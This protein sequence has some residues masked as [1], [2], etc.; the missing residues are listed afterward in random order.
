M[1]NAKGYGP[2]DDREFILNPVLWPRW[3]L[4]PLKRRNDKNPP[5]DCGLLIAVDPAKGKLAT[6]VFCAYLFGL[7]NGKTIKELLID[8]PN[9]ERIEYDNVDALLADGWVVD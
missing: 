7:Q 9:V 4:L 1:A 3:P 2:G 8:N 5:F 6:T